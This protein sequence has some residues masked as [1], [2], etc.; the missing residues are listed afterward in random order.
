M[1]LNL[2]NLLFVHDKF[3]KVCRKT[4]PSFSK[5]LFSF[6]ACQLK[7]EHLRKYND[8]YYFVDHSVHLQVE[9]ENA[10]NSLVSSSLSDVNVKA[11]PRWPPGKESIGERF[12]SLRVTVKM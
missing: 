11:G 1:F 9:V 3:N 12:S 7:D 8:L 5:I 4:C 10:I 6:V 2:S